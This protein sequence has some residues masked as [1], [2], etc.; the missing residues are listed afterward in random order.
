M[1]VCLHLFD[2]MMGWK[3]NS[4]GF[5]PQGGGL[6]LGYVEFFYLWG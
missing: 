3:A 1:S 2:W 6:L 5:A 4:T